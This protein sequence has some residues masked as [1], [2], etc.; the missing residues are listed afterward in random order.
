[1]K[2]KPHT[3][4]GD[5]AHL[6][7]ALA[8]LTALDHW[9][10]WRWELRRGIWTK[11]PYTTGGGRAKNNDPATWASY[12]AALAAADGGNGGSFDGIGFALLDT[13]FDVVDLDHCLDPATGQIDEWARTWI[14]AAGGAYIE[15]TP[16]GEGL[17]II[18]ATSSTEKLHRKW[19]IQGVREKAAIEIYRN[20][21][22]YIT[23]TGIQ[24][25]ECKSLGEAN[26]LL[27]QIQA[28]FGAQAR[29]GAGFNCS[30]AG[31]SS[32]IDYDAV[33]R[34]GAPVGANVSNLFQRD[35]PPQRQG[36]VDR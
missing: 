24:V 21:E 20:A 30:D 19:S 9:L 31:T 6:P 3:L 26:G 2:Q 12:Q 18:A 17:R 28:H 7:A 5:L 15:R 29:N 8:P 23:V 34:G 27:E 32:K 35:R 10:L 11:P 33:I 1:M 16:S 22:R 13:P 4:K 14:D 36:D 25:G